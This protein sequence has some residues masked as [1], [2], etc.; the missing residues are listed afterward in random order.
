MCIRDR[1]R[2]KLGIV[3]PFAA[4][5]CK[6][7]FKAHVGALALARH[8]ALRRAAFGGTR[9]GPVG[10][11]ALLENCPRLRAAPGGGWRLADAA[12]LRDI[13]ARRAHFDAPL[14]YARVDV[15]VVDGATLL[16]PRR[17]AARPR[18]RADH[19]RAAWTRSSACSTSS[20]RTAATPRPR[21]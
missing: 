4:Q 19:P 21:S 12:V 3:H 6:Q 10:V 11:S 9:A 2:D 8:E 15:A 20:R 7:S 14:A 17:S 18:P 16:L 5:V 13:C 1:P